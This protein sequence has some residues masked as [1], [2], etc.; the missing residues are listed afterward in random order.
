MG[1]F[2]TRTKDY[3]VYQKL[4]SHAVPPCLQTYVGKTWK[5]G[6]PVVIE[7]VSFGKCA[8]PVL[9]L[10][11]LLK[12]L[13]K[14]EGE[15]KRIPMKR[16]KD[17]GASQGG[18]QLNTQPKSCHAL[19]KAL[20]EGSVYRRT[21]VDVGC[22]Q[23]RVLAAATGKVGVEKIVGYEVDEHT[24][25]M[26]EKNLKQCGNVEVKCLDVLELDALPEDATHLTTM[27]CGFPLS[28][29]FHLLELFCRSK[30]RRV[31]LTIGDNANGRENLFH[32]CFYKVPTIATV[33]IQCGGGHTM[34]VYD[35]PAVRGHVEEYLKQAKALKDM[36][37]TCEGSKIP[38]SV[39]AILALEG[40]RGVL[41]AERR[42][43][44][45]NGNKRKRC[46]PK[47]HPIEVLTHEELDQVDK[48]KRRKKSDKGKKQWK[49]TIIKVE[50]QSI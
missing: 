41:L 3:K 1:R 23:G 43:K 40:A 38:L 48:Q 29:Q 5:R 16:I 49:T 42:H 27:N 4:K 10:L 32:D 46:K 11:K 15:K 36:R 14:V 44:K 24:A 7:G 21:F 8:N 37:E 34:Q 18:T 6:K 47:R 26:A 28:L 45:A 2:A 17:R 31:A 39:K 25:A 20:F 35:W 30:L 22:S 19:L 12:Y 33:P 13:V 9:F 50:E